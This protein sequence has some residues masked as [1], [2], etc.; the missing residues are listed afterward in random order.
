MGNLRRE[1]THDSTTTTLL[2]MCGMT[3][4]V[5][6]QWAPSNSCPESAQTKQFSSTFRFAVRRERAT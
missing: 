5:G 6:D 2:F 1:E 4:V 3:K